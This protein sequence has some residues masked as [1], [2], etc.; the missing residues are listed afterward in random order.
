MKTIATAALLVSSVSAFAGEQC[1]QV[2]ANEVD[3]SRTP[4]VLCVDGDVQ[5][6][7]FAITLKSGLPFDETVVATFNLNLLQRARCLDCNSDVYGLANPSNATFNLL[8]IKFNGIRN[9]GTGKEEG[10]V[11]IGATKLLYRSL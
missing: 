4:E 3:W 11:S 7:E 6:N 5:K 9:L 8:S 10:T 1:Y 2:S